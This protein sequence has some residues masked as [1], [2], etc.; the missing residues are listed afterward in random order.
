MDLASYQQREKTYRRITVG[1]MLGVRILECGRPSLEKGLEC[2]EIGL[3]QL[4]LDTE[5]G[6][7]ALTTYSRGQRW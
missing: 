2:M 5:R 4:R 7:S 3:P 6:F 1:A